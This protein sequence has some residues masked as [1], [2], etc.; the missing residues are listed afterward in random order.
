MIIKLTKEYTLGSKKYTEIN[1]DMES[2]N[3]N[4]FKECNRNYKARFKNSNEDSFKDFDDEWALTVAEKAT[5]IKYGDLLK[6]GAL[7]YLRVV[8][9][10]KTF[11]LKGWETGEAK[12]EE[13]QVE[14]DL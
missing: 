12:K 7:D 6:L 14:M 3:G 8:N 2:L 5:G 9:N 11:L 13:T 1:L 10:T 4:S